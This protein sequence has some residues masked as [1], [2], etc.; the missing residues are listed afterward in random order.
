MHPLRS[1]LVWCATTYFAEGFPYSLVRQISSVYFKDHQASLPAIGMT[2]L[3]GLPWTLKFLWAPYLDRYGTKRKWI[4]A[5]E[6]LLCLFILAFAG[7]SHTAAA[8]RAGAMLFML[9]AV[10]AATHDIAIDGY[11]LEALDRKGQARFVGYRVMAYRIALIAGAGGIVTLSH[12]LG[13]AMAMAGAALVLLLLFLY[14]AFFLPAAEKETLPIRALLTE[15]SARRAAGAGLAAL[16]VTGGIFLCRDRPSVAGLLD[17][18]GKVLPPA[19]WVSVALLAAL[20]V[21]LVLRNRI[22]RRLFGSGSF[23]ANAFLAFLDQERIGWALA[24]IVLYRTGESLLAAMTAPFLLDLGINKAQYGVLSGTFGILF[25]ILGALTGGAC[26]ARYSL[27][28]TIWPF[29][30]AQNLTNLV[31]MALAYAYRS[32]LLPERA[33]GEVSLFVVGGVHCF[34][35]FAGGLGT[36]VFSFYLMRCCRT[37]FKA[38]HFAIVSGIMSVGGIVFGMTSGFLASWLGYWRF[39]GLSF[40]ASLPGMCL[41]GWIPFLKENPE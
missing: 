12:Y 14:H 16:L 1:P 24:F 22:R 29:T 23:Y 2:S 6:C 31:Y 36:A 34:D 9:I 28:K 7:T 17:A 11:Y 38:S 27:A 37:E 19:G 21:L 30:L 20:V 10:L 8:L 26:I 33:A 5:L 3:Y 18:M 39:F 40:L 35:Q 13:W 4:L 25:S 15:S 41:I 32:L